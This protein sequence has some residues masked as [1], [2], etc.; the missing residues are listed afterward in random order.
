MI[1]CKS[2]ERISPQLIY[3][4]ITL[5]IFRLF[6]RRFKFYSISKYKLC[7]IVLSAI[8]TMLYIRSSD[9]IHLITASLHSF[10]K[11]ILYQGDS[12]N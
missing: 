7:N 4:S 11:Y 9:L 2:H 8:V 10:L 6:V 3:T 12:V 1:G 5:P